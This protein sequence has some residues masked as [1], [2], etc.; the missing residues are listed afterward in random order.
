MK[1]A[2][3]ALVFL[4]LLVIALSIYGAGMYAGTLSVLGLI[5]TL[6]ALLLVPTR[7]RLGAPATF[8]ALIVLYTVLT[9]LPLPFDRLFSGP[10]RTRQNEYARMAI[11]AS[12]NVAHSH[13]MQP[14]FSLSRN[15]AGTMRMVLH[16]IVAL[17]AAAIAAGLTRKARARYLR[18]LVILVALMAAGGIITQWIAPT[19]GTMWGLFDVAKGRDTVGCFV[20]R[21]HFGGYIALLCPAAI[22]LAAGSLRERRLPMLLGWTGC[23]LIMIAAVVGSL[24]R[25]AL[26]ALTGGMLVTLVAITLPVRRAAGATSM[27]LL[28]C[29]ALTAGRTADEVVADR[30]GSIA[31]PLDTVS[32][33]L[34][35]TTWRDALHIFRAYPIAGV[36]AN[37]FKTVFPQFRKESTRKMA[38]YVEN[39]YVQLLA[40]MGVVGALLF[41]LL[42]VTVVRAWRRGVR[43]QHI[44]RE[45]SLSVLGATMVA[46]IH[47]L[48][49]FPIR[50]PLYAFL[51]ASLLGMV[52]A[53]PPAPNSDLQDTRP[54]SRPNP[55]L[56]AGPWLAIGLLIAILV[57]LQGDRIYRYDR[58]R[59]LKTMR[60]N[61]LIRALT[62]APTS[63][64]TWYYLGE[65]AMDRDR[66]AAK[67]FGERCISVAAAYNPNRASLW[68][69]VGHARL[70]LGRPR[71]AKRAFDRATALRHWIDVPNVSIDPIDP[72]E[73]DIPRPQ[74]DLEEPLE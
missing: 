20:N 32:A 4:V 19:I 13:S 54:P 15:R 30:I 3:A 64:Q 36:G 70:R 40:D 73:M 28:L 60:P 59:S 62:W 33:H 43:D 53:R 65:T 11:Q 29:L 18:T 6:A 50:I 35:L 49:D 55:F 2:T 72:D 41:A 24:S 69:R 37:G 56:Y 26:I 21:N 31:K 44:S 58:S 16:M 63:W 10:K 51:L 7:R 61:Q 68:A 74:A 22:V 17:G 12:D 5:T 67:R 57:T 71:S 45:L 38:H 34:R 23:L 27:L 42:A 46:L 52:V 39:E 1:R 8:A 48:F 14:V 66:I 9:A 25:G 47:A